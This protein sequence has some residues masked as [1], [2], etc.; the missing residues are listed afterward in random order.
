M[1]VNEKQSEGIPILIYFE[2]EI[3]KFFEKM[4]QYVYIVVFFGEY[5]LTLALGVV[6]DR[7]V[8]RVCILSYFKIM[9]LIF[10]Y[11]NICDI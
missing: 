9:K 2:Q 10:I 1:C 7:V 4:R 5:R 8:N 6:G 3:R 11:N